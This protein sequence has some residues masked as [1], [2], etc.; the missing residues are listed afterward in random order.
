MEFVSDM[1]FEHKTRKCM[2]KIIHLLFTAL[3][4][5]FFSC[6]EKE[7]VY[8]KIETLEITPTFALSFIA[9]GNIVAIGSSPVLEYGFVYG[10]SSNPDIFQATKIALGTTNTPGS[11]EKNISIEF[12]GVS[13]IYIRSYLT[14]EKGTVYGAVKEFP[15]PLLNITSVSP[16][17]A[18]AGAQVTLTGINF[19]PV[20][21]EN[22]V[23]FNG[24]VAILSGGSTTSLVAEVPDGLMD[25]IYYDNIIIT[26]TIGGQEI[27]ATQNF[28]ILPTIFDFSPK[29]GTFGTTVILSGKDFSPISAIQVE[30]EITSAFNI[31]SSSLSFSIPATV[32]TAKLKMDLIMEN[33]LIEIPGEFTI[34]PPTITSV[35]PLIGLSGSKVVI[36]G[37]GFNNGNFLNS[38]NVVKFGTQVATTFI[39][40]FDEIT[41]FAPAGLSVGTYKISVF[42]GVHTVTY[43]P[44]YTVTTPTITSFSPTSGLAGTYVTITGTNFG[45]RNPEYSVLFGSS[46]VGI[47]SWNNTSITV[48]IPLGTSPGAVKITLNIAGQSVTSAN[49]Y[50]ILP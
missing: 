42:T 43:G 47:Y 24:K 31:S 15:L 39:S 7:E 23:K 1:Y 49:D 14:N 37:T 26:V 3:L 45:E 34:N 44:N 6:D 27:I 18:K 50:T 5:T 32:T 20:T 28:K 2:K 29:A 17:K 22:T 4:I 12:P 48:L 16:M 25:P 41:A 10:T 13:T 21:A 40:S 46:P 33:E 36:V 9:K 30:N 8:P 38:Y 11:F 19:N 35:T